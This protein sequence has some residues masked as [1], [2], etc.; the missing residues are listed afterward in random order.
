MN[1]D[2]TCNICGEPASNFLSFGGGGKAI[3]CPRCL[4]FE[5]HRRFKDAFDR[6]MRPEF[7][8]ADKEVL[9]CVPGKAELEYFFVGAKRVVSFDVRPV[10]WFDM[11]MDLT[12]MKQIPDASVDVVMLIAVL[13]HVEQDHL[14]PGE[15]HRV[16]RSG[17]RCLLQATNHRAPTVGYPNLHAHYSKEEFEK[18]RVGTFRIYRDLDLISLFSKQFV[19]KTFYGEDPVCGGIDFILSAEKL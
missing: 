19:T 3:R 18:Y 13:Q 1:L 15:V 12:D 11:Q 4:S 5:R 9:A 16:L 14:V 8:F 10:E 2:K 7:S 6:Y 17:G